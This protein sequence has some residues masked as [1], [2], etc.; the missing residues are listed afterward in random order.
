MAFFLVVDFAT[1]CFLGSYAVFS[2]ELLP[3]FFCYSLSDGLGS[4]A[5]PFLFSMIHNFV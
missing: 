2:R 5:T 3:R 4:A 1:C